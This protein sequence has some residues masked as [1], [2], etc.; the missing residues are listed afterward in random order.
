MFADDTSISYASNSVQELQNI[1]N[2]E[3]KRLNEWLVT[4]KL[5]L[6]VVKTEFMIIGSRQRIEN[7]TDTIDIKLNNNKI[8]E[9]DCVK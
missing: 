7:L 3:L 9:V 6:N 4:N 1:I 2:S 8:K 5:S